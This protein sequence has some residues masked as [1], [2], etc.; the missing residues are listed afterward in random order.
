MT[1][2]I[3]PYTATP[4]KSPFK[5]IA[6]FGGI[7]FIGGLA[8]MGWVVSNWE[9]A[10][11]LI[12]PNAKPEAEP[13]ITPA[14]AAVAISAA[15]VPLPPSGPAAA[16]EN[17]NRAEGLMI[18]AAVRRAIA[19]GQSLGYLETALRQHFGATQP[20]A[21]ALIISN[22]K[23]PVTRE[24][25]R[26]ELETQT[27]SLLGYG[28][29]SHWADRFRL[30]FSDLVVIRDANQPSSFGSAKIDRARRYVDAGQYEKAIE[31]VR[32]LPGAD[33][34]TTWINSATQFAQTEKAI[35]LLETAAI[36]VPPTPVAPVIIAPQMPVAP[37]GPPSV[38]PPAAPDP[39][40]KTPPTARQ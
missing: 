31:E 39:A 32:S 17:A 24:A 26:K 14:A 15:P 23:K 34:A 7:A 19:Q 20:S 22:A 12:L 36:M 18:A 28:P 16:F 10:R 37:A 38:A 35:N 21:V 5:R 2:Q 9:P 29:D 3:N 1:D 30:T 27:P 40:Q 25:L 6:L 11:A 13:A 8:A 33:A 4:R